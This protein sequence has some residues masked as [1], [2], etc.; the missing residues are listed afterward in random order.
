MTSSKYRNDFEHFFHEEMDYKILADTNQY[1][2]VSSIIAPNKKVQVVLTDSPAGT[3]KTALA[4][5]SAYYKLLKGDIQK[6]IYVRNSLSVRDSGFLP[7]SAEEKEMVY[8][9]P[10]LDVIERIGIKLGRQD[11]VRDLIREEQIECVSTSYLRGVDYDQ[12][13]ILIID[14]AQNMDLIELQTI[15]T[16]PHDN[17][18]VIM[19][20]SSL[21][22]DNP[23]IR[24]Y[25]INKL[26]PFEVYIDHLMSQSLFPV[27]YV[28]LTK[29]YRGNLSNHADKIQD[30]IKR[31]IS[32]G[33]EKE[34][35]IENSET[36]IKLNSAF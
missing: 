33:K 21:Q 5:T 22:N 17:V 6:I 7:G 4:I 11:L 19:I 29:N 10:F 24:T 16:R 34:A 27:E 14:E 36:V 8:M 13:A 23:K 1:Q 30:T 3:G 26:L 9:K 35:K 32:E 12:D 28:E 20:G 15:L 25:G 31:I 18:K 2:Y